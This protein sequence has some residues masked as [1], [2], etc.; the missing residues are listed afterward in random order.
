MPPPLQAFHLAV[1]PGQRFCLFHSARGSAPRGRVL[2]VHP[3]AEEMNKSRRMAALQARAL[4]AAGFAVLQIDLYGC[5]DSS[6]DVADASWSGWVDDLVAAQAWLCA[7]AEGPTWLWGLRA[8]CLLA[9]QAAARIEEP[10]GFLFWQPA[11]S[12]KSLVQ[13]FL[14]LK[15][16]NELIGGAGKGVIAQLRQRLDSGVAVQV[17]GYELSPALVSGFEAATLAPPSRGVLGGRV[18]WI[19]VS[20]QV[21]SDASAE[22]GISPASATALARWRAAGWDVRAQVVAGPAFWQSTE[23]EEAP[24]LLEASVGALCGDLPACETPT[25]HG[26]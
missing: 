5:G 20:A 25:H 10:C 8:G 21:A 24:R 11:L 7:H 22:S 1:A 19:D 2:Y 23:I 6:G 9:V 3:F 14:R 18:E 4:A 15:A 12:G 13:Q 26:G 17:A 16:A